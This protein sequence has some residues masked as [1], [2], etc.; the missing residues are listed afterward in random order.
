MVAFRDMSLSDVT[1][2]IASNGSA[3]LLYVVFAQYQL[4]DNYY[5]APPHCYYRG[6]EQRDDWYIMYKAAARQYRMLVVFGKRL[7]MCCSS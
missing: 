1:R 5:T 3:L 7:D 2:G 4:R 6:R